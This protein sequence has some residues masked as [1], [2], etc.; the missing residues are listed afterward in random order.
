MNYTL[1]QLRIYAEIVHS[2]SVSKAAERLHL[3][4][5]A[6]SI[7][8]KNF[9]SQFDIPLTEFVGRKLYITDFGKEI[10]VSAQKILGEL[11]AINN[12]TQDYKGRLSGRL[13]LAV[14]STGKYVIPYFLSGFLRQHEGVELLLEVTNR[15]EV[16]RSLEANAV[17]FALVSVPVEKMQLQR[18]TLMQNQLYF[19]GNRDAPVETPFYSRKT[20]QSIP[21]IYREKGSGTRQVMEKYILQHK[22]TVQKKLELTSNEAVKQAVISGMGY[23]VMPLIGIK[24]ELNNGDLRIL[25]V[26]DFPIHSSWELLWLKEKGFS[27]VARRYLEYLRREKQRIIEQQFSW[28]ESYK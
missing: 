18:L 12:R 2:S 28:I 8:L 26:R 17:D 6:V 11:E 20:L 21:L 13:K 24:N 22:L 14:V 7:Q 27:M 3:S 15:A 10:A 25:P 4:Q 16:I 23:S 1:N 9:Q 5:P 19:V